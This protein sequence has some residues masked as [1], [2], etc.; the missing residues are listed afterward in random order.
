MFGL[1][2]SEV[3][4][5]F[6]IA[7]IFIGPKKLPELAKNIGKGLREFQRAKN[8]LMDDINSEHGHNPHNDL[9]NLN[10]QHDVAN[11]E[12]LKANDESI[13]AEF[14]SSSETCQS[15]PSDEKD[16]EKNS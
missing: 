7:L 12:Q 2:M 9:N 11:S 5:I 3:L 13:E 1:G 14:N 4:I 15:T 6:V 8:G 10:G 16:S